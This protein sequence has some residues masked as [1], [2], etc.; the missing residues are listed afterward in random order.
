MRLPKAI[1]FSNRSVA[2]IDDGFYD[3][4]FELY[5]IDKKPVVIHSERGEFID[6]NVNLSDFAVVYHGEKSC[7][8]YELETT[9]VYIDGV[10]YDLLPRGE[11]LLYA[12]YQNY[13]I[14][15]IIPVIETPPPNIDESERI[16]WELSHKKQIDLNA[17]V[18]MVESKTT[19]FIVP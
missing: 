14:G 16:N 11:Y 8:N 5:T 12:K 18:G 17:W 7:I 6:E 4:G 13:L 2:T 15:N 3:L 19:K 10:E 1:G 9:Q